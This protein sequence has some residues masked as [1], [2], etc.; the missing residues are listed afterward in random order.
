MNSSATARILHLAL[1]SSV[2][3]STLVMSVVPIP[4]ASV[5]PLFLYAVFGVAAVLFGGAL[6]I[7]ARLPREGNPSSDTWWTQNLSRAL[8]IWALLEGPS[9]L[10]AVAFMLSRDYTALLIPAI[11]FTLFFLHSPGRLEQ[12]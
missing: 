1:M 7:A 8:V 6:V 4:G 12:G 5:S 2:V 10:G 3:L 11:G 9:L